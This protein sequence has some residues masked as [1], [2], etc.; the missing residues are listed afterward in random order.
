MKSTLLVAVGLLPICS[1]V[2]SPT[3]WCMESD[4]SGAYESA[5]LYVTDA[6]GK[7]YPHN[8]TPSWG[9]D[10]DITNGIGHDDANW[11]ISALGNDGLGF[12]DN[13]WVLYRIPVSKALDQNFD[14][15]PGVRKV[16]SE[17]VPTLFNMRYGHAGD[18]DCYRH[19]D[20]VD[21]LFVPL[22]GYAY[23]G[24][25]APP[26]AIAVFRADDLHYVNYA[27]LP[28]QEGVGWCAIDNSGRL[29][30][31]DNQTNK[32]LE[33]EI[34]WDRVNDSGRHD[35]LIYRRPHYLKNRDGTS[36]SLHHMQGGAFSPSNN[37]LYINCG[38]FVYQED[39][40]GIHV[41]ETETWTEEWASFNSGFYYS[42]C[43][44]YFVYRFENT[45]GGGDEP[46]GLTYWDLNEGRAPN[47][48][49]ELHVL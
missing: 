49:G 12:P 46:E 3:T 48:R 25:E 45:F 29:Y 37:L 5:Y 9:D 20:G 1:V 27:I 42:L 22:T 7:D 33:Y 13:T 31:S 39:T 2:L 26:P 35:G 19:S 4:Q 34:I 32:I 21:Y 16:L 30:T 41:F 36:L 38:I 28:V 10:G 18:V 6:E 14:N 23:G 40:D 44:P 24:N 11:Y 43:E 17:E 15:D 8:G 47:V